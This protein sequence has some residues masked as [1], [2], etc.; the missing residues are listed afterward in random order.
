VTVVS[1][2]AG[3]SLVCDKFRPLPD[4]G[5]PLDPTLDASWRLTIDTATDIGELPMQDFNFCPGVGYR[6]IS[7]GTAGDVVIDVTWEALP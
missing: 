4:S 3:F 6:A 5:V 2:P 1:A 7:G